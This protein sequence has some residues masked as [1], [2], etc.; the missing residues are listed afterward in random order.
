TKVSVAVRPPPSV[1]VSVTT[2]EPI[3]PAAGATVTVR[4]APDP[5]S[6]I[7]DSGRRVEFEDDA[8]TVRLPAGVSMSPTV[9]AIGPDELSCGIVTLP[10]GESVGGFDTSTTKVAVAVAPCG[11][12]TVRVTVAVPVWFGSGVTNIV[13]SG[14]DTPRV[15]PLFR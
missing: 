4:F 1:T 2:D 6:T 14:P 15:I 9:K 5:P 13:R 3:C 10:T 12:V 8:A 7:P 11:S